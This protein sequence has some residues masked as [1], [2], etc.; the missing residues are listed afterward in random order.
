M[1]KPQI[2]ICFKIS[3]SFNF[4]P[5]PLST[6]ATL[7]SIRTE[8]LFCTYSS[9]DVVF[10]FRLSRK[11]HLALKFLGR[12]LLKA[13]PNHLG[14]GHLVNGFSVTFPTVDSHQTPALCRR[15]TIK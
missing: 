15:G 6:S 3:V 8:A 1:K 13:V 4:L 10:Y 14:A 7:G 9:K 12:L 5:N 11:P 2:S